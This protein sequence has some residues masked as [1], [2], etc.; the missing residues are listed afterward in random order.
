MNK[1][2][3]PWSEDVNSTQYPRPQLQRQ[4]WQS[5]DGYWQCAFVKGNL[6]SPDVY[7]TYCD[8]SILVPFS[9]ESFLSQVGRTTMP[10]EI[11]VYK[12]HFSVLE[13][14]RYQFCISAP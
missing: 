3:T 5:L 12:T 7:K 10:D 11:L 6:D 13:K 8:T 14:I 9:P 2:K 1:L 4:N